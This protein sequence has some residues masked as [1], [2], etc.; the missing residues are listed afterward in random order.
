MTRQEEGSTTKRDGGDKPHPKLGIPNQDASQDE[1]LERI[2]LSPLIFQSS[3]ASLS[4][5]NQ[6]LIAP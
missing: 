2:K 3:S 6:L 5:L 4:L 1:Y